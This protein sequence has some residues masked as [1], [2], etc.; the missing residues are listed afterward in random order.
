MAW[1]GGCVGI[2]L[3]RI[4]GWQRLMKQGESNNGSIPGIFLLPGFGK[5]RI[6]NVFRCPALFVC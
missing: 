6:N 4:V 2:E 5:G 1:H 3:H